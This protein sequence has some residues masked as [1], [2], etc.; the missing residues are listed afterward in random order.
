MLG[1]WALFSGI[2]DNCSLWTGLRFLT[3]SPVQ[4]LWLLWREKGKLSIY[5]LE[6]IRLDE[7][8]FMRRFKSGCITDSHPL[9]G[10]LMTCLSQC[11]F[12]QGSEDLTLLEK[13]KTGELLKS[14]STNSSD[15]DIIMYVSK[16]SSPLMFVRKLMVFKSHNV[17]FQ[18]PWGIFWAPRNW[19]PWCTFAGLWPYL[20]HISDPITHIATSAV[21]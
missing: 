13:A 16:K 14:K 7:W 18:S 19:H 3:S 20:G 8:H 5:S 1:K 17:H 6:R 9:Y 2:W 15:K 4:R 10:T 21:T 11:I 12:E